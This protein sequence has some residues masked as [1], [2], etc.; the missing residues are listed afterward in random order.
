LLDHLVAL[1]VGWCEACGNI[2][3]DEVPLD[4]LV[5]ESRALSGIQELI[6]SLQKPHWARLLS[7][8]CSGFVVIV[9][10]PT[11]NDSSLASS[12][13]SPQLRIRNTSALTLSPAPR[14]SDVV[15]QLAAVSASTREIG[16]RSALELIAEIFINCVLQGIDVC[17][18]VV[19]EI[20]AP[21]RFISV[22]QLVQY[23]SLLLRESEHMVSVICALCSEAP[24]KT[25][26][27][28]S[29]HIVAL[30]DGVARVCAFSV[31][32]PQKSQFDWSDDVRKHISTFL[33]DARSLHEVCRATQTQF[34]ESDSNSDL[35]QKRKREEVQEVEVGVEEE[36]EDVGKE[37]G[38][39]EEYLDKQEGSS[40]GTLVDEELN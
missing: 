22:S 20:R 29:K 9:E 35:N 39:A 26:R 13:V 16:Y 37:E 4:Q 36:E 27:A 24:I 6:G 3:Q 28:I 40:Q 18:S 21:H 31:G 10:E 30:C 15:N 33:A 8:D 23:L 14:T 12:T 1:L 32:S 19:S 17:V 5:L 25:N 7:D 34:K 38:V 11:L 2:I